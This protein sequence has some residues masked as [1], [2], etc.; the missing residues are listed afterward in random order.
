LG[1][2]DTCAEP[3][4]KRLQ[5]RLPAPRCTDSPEVRLGNLGRDALFGP[6]LLQLDAALS[7]LFSLTERYRLEA[8]FEDFSAINHTN[9]AARPPPSAARASAASLARQS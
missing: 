2:D 8:H 6:G 9:F 4:E 1:R 3:P 7:R 5:A